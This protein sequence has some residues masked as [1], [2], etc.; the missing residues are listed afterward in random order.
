VHAFAE[1]GKPAQIPGP[2]LRVRVGTEVRVMI[3][4]ELGQN[5]KIRGFFERKPGA[6]GV[7][8]DR[9]VIEGNAIDIAVGESREIR[10]RATVPGNFFYWGITPIDTL[11]AYPF[12]Q[13]GAPMPMFSPLDSWSAP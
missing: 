11:A 5:L 1:E 3:R 4:N 8:L 7:P 9:Q 6:Q 12:R 13:P 10:F 2:L